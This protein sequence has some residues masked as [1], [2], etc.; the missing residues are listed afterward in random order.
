[1]VPVD[2]SELST[3]TATQ[4]VDLAREVKARITFLYAT[5]DYS[6]TAD[7]AVV[8][9]LSPA[10]FAENSQDATSAIL[11]KVIEIGQM[12]GVGCDGTSVVTDHPHE[13]IIKTALVKGCDLIFMASHGKRGLR[14][15][16]RGSQ[17]EKVVRNSPIPVLVSSVETI[18]PHA[19]M[20]RALAVIQDEHRSLSVVIRALLDYSDETQ[21][22]GAALD[23]GIVRRMVSYLRDF[24]GALHHPKEER[25]IFSRLRERTR[26]FDDQLAALERQHLREHELVAAVERALSM[27][28]SGYSSGAKAFND[29]FHE[30]A[31]HIREHIGLEERTILPAARAY[32]TDDDWVAID[33]AFA[34]NCDPCFGDI[35]ADEFSKLF[36][37]IARLLPK[38]KVSESKET[39]TA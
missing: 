32:L 33:K 1:L 21:Y 30:L 7:G 23:T 25:H 39:T 19:P 31:S 38:G 20:H 26:D 5:P 16:M 29:A 34:E 28:E 3:H 27:H 10:A 4:A 35:G 12:K 37:K 8:R 36:T 13:A 24:P 17:T 9:T 6:A 18:D 15:F 11:A 2:G 14:G 22:D